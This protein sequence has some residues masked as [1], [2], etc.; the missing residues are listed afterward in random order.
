[1]RKT[2]SL[3]EAGSKID[4]SPLFIRIKISNLLVLEFE[5]EQEII[6]SKELATGEQGILTAG[7]VERREVK[8]SN[9]EKGG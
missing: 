5:I 1:M 9:L 3:L 7:M 6:K 4:L 8:K 2:V